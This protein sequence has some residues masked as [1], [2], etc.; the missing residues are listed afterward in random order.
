[1]GRAGPGR[2]AMPRAVAGGDA[3]AL[4]RH[5]ERYAG[6]LFGCLHR[7]AGDRMTAEA[8]L[9]AGSSSAAAAS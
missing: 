5:Y 9:H 4:P 3:G 6:P 7:L 8:I 1:M 2:A